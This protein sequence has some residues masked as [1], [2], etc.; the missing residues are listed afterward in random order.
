MAET[1]GYKAVIRMTGTPTAQTAQATALVTGKTYQITTASKRI[2]APTVAVTIKDNGVL[3][4]AANILSID[5]LFGM[6]TFIPAYTVVGAITF[7]TF[8]YLPTTAISY[9][10]SYDF[11]ISRDLLDSTVFNT[12]GFKTWKVGL[13]DAEGSISM[14]GFSDESINSETLIAKHV[15]GTSYLL[16]LDPTGAGT[17]YRRFW[18][19]LD[20]LAPKADVGGLV[21]D[22][23]SW[24]ATG[25]TSTDG[26]PASFAFG[27]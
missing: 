24:K 3:V 9:A 26:Y 23:I 19:K 13:K 22:T 14:V 1:A 20:S 6:V 12:T 21:E 10:K 2:I 17:E 7:A 11:S 8:T 15:A 5:Y 25:V 4:A 18:V 16:E 27:T